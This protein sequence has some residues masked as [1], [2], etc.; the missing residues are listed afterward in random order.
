M[1]WE[2]AAIIGFS[3]LACATACG[4]GGGND[5]VAST[6]AQASFPQGFLPVL[7]DGPSG[8]GDVVFRDGG[9]LFAV[10]GTD[11]LWVVSRANGAVTT[12]ENLGAGT[13]R[14]IA[15][16]DDGRLFVGNDSGGIWTI[17][18][19]GTPESPFVVTPLVTTGSGAIT[20]LA[21]AP[22]GFGDL[23][24]SLFAAKRTSGIRRIT[25]GD[26]P[27]VDP[28]PFSTG[29]YVDLAFAGTTLVAID[30]NGEIGEVST[31]GTFGDL[32]TPTPPFA[33]PVGIAVD[34]VNSEIYVADANPGVLYTVP[35]TGG[36][37]AARAAYSFDPDAPSGLAHDGVGALAFITADPPAIRGSTLPRINPANTNFGRSFAGPTVG[38]GDLE[39]DR[40]GAFVIAATDDDPQVSGDSTN[41]FLI[42]A[43]RDLTAVS[44]L[45]S[46]VGS[47]VEEI[48]GVAVDPLD[49]VIY[50]STRSGNVYER[51]SDGTVSL[52][53]S[54]VSSAILGLEIAPAGFTGF[55]G[56]LIATTQDGRIIP[57]D[58]GSQTAAAPIVQGLS[59]LVDLVFSA[60]GTL[61]VVENNES[62]SRI[63]RIASNGMVSDLGVPLAQL[64]RADG[65][66]IDEGG[67]RLLVASETAAGGQLLS[68]DLRPARLGEVRALADFT[69]DNGFFPTGVVYDRLGTAVVR[70]GDNS[71]SLRAF[72]V[73]LPVP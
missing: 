60:S 34:S 9:D 5:T 2:A 38:Y 7:L 73:P 54:A 16:G 19:D 52:L 48:L 56:D 23:G 62:T 58:P 53:V 3:A 1:R 51:A 49:D 55:A 6:T 63:L 24:G 14:S 43:S 21:L 71:T 67:N 42:S 35:V 57:I 10:Q 15:R 31:S 30:A 50:V 39:L 8:R 68:V 33:E 26:T 72:S 44:F 13:L 17:T 64:G 45:T 25:L 47:S 12:H 70:Q 37:K 20:G 32:A 69:I 40:S 46:P 36:A 59:H 41:N 28:V 18:G 65:I 29:D 61:Y 4:G 11:D 22:S 66:E 27:A